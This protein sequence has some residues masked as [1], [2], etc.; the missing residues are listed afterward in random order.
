MTGL[1]SRVTK[2][3]ATGLSVFALA[4]GLTMTVPTQAKATDWATIAVV[5]VGV[6]L[7][8]IVAGGATRAPAK[9][10]YTVI[11]RYCENKHTGLYHRC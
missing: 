11:A 8:G 7:V 10:A 6:T 9:P 1:L 2:R 5:A 4:A 3:V